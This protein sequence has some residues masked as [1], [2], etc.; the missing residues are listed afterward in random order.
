MKRRAFLIASGAAAGGLAVGVATIAAVD[1]PAGVAVAGEGVVLGG[2]VRIAPD[3]T[4]TVY[5]PHVDMGQGVHTA[6]AMLLAD[7]LDAD[8]RHVRAE[9]APADKAFANRF[10]AE[11][12][13]LQDR[14]L[15]R[16]LDG[17]V[18]TM[19]GLAA[20]TMNLQ[21]TGGSTAVRFTGQVGMRTI[22]AG[23]RSLLLDA[24]AAR[25]D[26][27][28]SELTAERST[29]TH[30]ASGRRA[31]Y[32]ELA[33]DAARRS[34]PSTPRLKQ[35]AEFKIVGTSPPRLDIPAK[36]RGAAPYDIDLQLPGMLVA[37]V[38]AAPVHGET[39]QSV[40]AAPALAIRGVKRVLPLADAVAVVADGYWAA[41][42]GADALTPV[43]ADR[44][45]RHIDSAAI[46]RAHELA[47]NAGDGEAA[48]E[49]GDADAALARAPADRI[50][51]ALYRVPFLHH[52]AMQPISG[53]AR[54]A[55][56]ALTVWAGQQDPLSSKAALMKLS[57]LPAD[58]VQ[59]VALP[60]GGAFG[61]RGRSMPTGDAMDHLDQLVRIA[62]EMS[63]APVKLIWSREEDFTRGVYRPAFVSDLRAALGGDG[64]PL[65]WRHRFVSHP[66][67]SPAHEL[68]YEIP[69]QSI[70]S[71]ESPVHVR[72]G[73]WRA[74]NHTQHGFFTECF[75]DELARAAWRDPMQYRRE[76]LP[77]ASRAR[78][79]LDHAARVSNWGQDL[80]A[81]TARGVAL[82]ESHGS[83][84]AQVAEVSLDADRRPRV[85]RIVAA[86]DCGPRVHPDTA[87]QQV[88]G[89]V[90]MGLS[91]ALYEHI[92][93]AG[94]AVVQKNFGDY[95]LLTMASTPR[96]DV[97]FV[98][99][100]SAWGGLGEPAVPGVAPAVANALAALTGQRS[101]SL[102]LGHL[103]LVTG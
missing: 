89:G 88:E 101:R 23:A 5:V 37:T 70:R 75:I 25:W 19:F 67:E 96:I 13:I 36:V 84:V 47:L 10:L 86:V 76:L 81:G 92:D 72:T 42:R 102:P 64:R 60:V 71:V 98:D 100:G 59:L 18:D 93:I 97:H 46:F 1:A 30:A 11:G 3:D 49:R 58:K 99:G 22:G 16:L 40:D 26:V 50:V 52:A 61:R 83:M 48:V 41:R 4:V 24:A 8:W 6:L 32:G 77:A 2:W 31:R 20:R 57:G 38:R 27:P 7:E 29:V 55:D 68:L 12:W 51:K 21:L 9:Q 44:G 15:P 43:F 14:E 90:L 17:L 65:A 78:R 66:S 33:A 53:C 79:V 85:H 82:T 28:V 74:V 87:R 73:A 34:M 80:P 63:P 95:R 35:A 69:H 103:Q 39:L 62:R 91:A 45:H 94:G 56:G 54:F